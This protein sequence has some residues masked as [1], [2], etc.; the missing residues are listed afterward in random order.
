[1]RNSHLNTGLRL[2]LDQLVRRFR[3][4]RD[5]KL[6]D[7]ARTALLTFLTGKLSPE[8]LAEFCKMA[9]IDAGQAMD[10]E[11]DFPMPRTNEQAADQRHARLAMRAARVPELVKNSFAD[12]FRAPPRIKVSA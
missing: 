11:E 12:R 2:A 10:D 3:T 9:G 7:E 5:E 4:A 8:D 1:M 6:S